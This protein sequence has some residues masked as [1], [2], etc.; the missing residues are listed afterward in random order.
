M[1]PLQTLHAKDKRKP[2]NMAQVDGN[3]QYQPIKIDFNNPQLVAQL[4]KGV[5]S[6][7]DPTQDAWA[8]P[9]PPPKGLYRLKLF[10]S[11]EGVKLDYRDRKNRKPEEAYYTAN[12]E[13]R[14]VDNKD[15]LNRIIFAGA[16]TNIRQGK[17]ISTM[18]GLLVKMGLKMQ[19]GQKVDDFTVVQTFLKALAKEPVL[20]G[21]I[22]WSGGYKPE[23]TA[24]NPNPY[25][26]NVFKTM[27]EFPV[28]NGVR[29][30]LWMHTLASGA[31]EEIRAQARVNQWYGAN[32]KVEAP[33]TAVATTVEEV[34]APGIVGDFGAFGG[35]VGSELAQVE[36]G[37]IASDIG[38]SL[39]FG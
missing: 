10:L 26:K 35:L 37:G 21:F 17:E 13:C 2:N 7:I 18:I 28:V 15:Y 34:T 9:P 38:D 31:R 30:H 29:Q 14:I 1:D 16:S 33:A 36:T 5:A 20:Q 19:S 25:Y 32:E 6:V 22:D 8:V 11:D 4:P 3:Q 24:Q 27:D 39:A 12:L 23:A